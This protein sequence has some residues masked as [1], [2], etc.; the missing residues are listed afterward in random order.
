TLSIYVSDARATPIASLIVNN[1]PVGG[2]ETHSVTFTPLALLGTHTLVA[3]ADARNEIDEVRE[4][5]NEATATLTVTGKPD[6]QIFPA[7]ITTVPAHLQPN[8]PGQITV[9]I[10]NNGAGDVA[11]AG[12]AIYDTYGSAPEVLLQRGTSGP[13]AATLSQTVQVPVSLAGG[14]HI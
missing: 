14:G 5:D 6:L 9:T 10:H 3:V 12:Y 4:D 11:A 8:Q 7:D 13:I 1:V 2:S